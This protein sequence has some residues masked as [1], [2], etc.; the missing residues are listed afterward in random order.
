MPILSKHMFARIPIT[1]ARSSGGVRPRRWQAP[2]LLCVLA[3]AFVLP[4]SRAATPTTQ[5]AQVEAT[6][7]RYRSV[8]ASQPTAD[9]HAAL[10]WVLSR[11]KSDNEQAL[12]EADEAL[13]LDPSHF[14]A[15]EIAALVREMQGRDDQVLPHLL[16]MIGQDRPETSYYISRVGELTLS[17]S[18]RRTAIE[19]LRGFVSQPGRSVHRAVARWVLAELLLRDGQMDQARQTYQDIGWAQAWQVVGPFDNEANSGFG[20][21]YGPEKEIDFTRKYPGRGSPVSWRK[22]EH[23]SL[24]GLCNFASVMYPNDQVLAYAVTYA[25]APARTQAVIRLGADHSVKVWVNNRLV[26]SDD[27]NKGFA[28]DQHVAPVVLEPGFNTILVKVCRHGGEWR[29]GLRLTDPAGNPLENVAFSSEPPAGSAATSQHASTPSGSP[30]IPERTA[31]F[32]HD[33]GMLEYFSQEVARNRQNESAVYYLG[34]AQHA[35][36]RRTPATQTFEWLVSL[37][38][39]CSEYRV[40]LALAYSVDEQPDKAFEQLKSA[41]SLEPKNPRALMMLG[42]FY[43]SRE[44]MELARKTL[45]AAVAAAP[46]SMVTHYAL[47]QFYQARG[48]AFQ[49]FLKAKTLHETHPE[50]SLLTANYAALCNGYGYNEQSKSLWTQAVAQDRTNLTAWQALMDQAAR[51]SRIDDALKCGEVLQHLLPLSHS[52]RLGRVDL[53]LRRQAYEPAIALCKESL[54]ICPTQADVLNRLG[55]IYERMGKTS[56][57]I[58]SWR[59]ALLHKPDDRSLRDYLDFLQPQ[60]ENAAFAQYGVGAREAADLIA[61][62]RI[63][64]ASYPKASAVILLRHR[65]TQLFEDGSS[66]SQEHVV[67]KILNERGRQEYTKV[68]LGGSQPKVLR[69]VVIKPDGSEVE[70]TRVTAQEIHF[71]QLQ[72]GSVLEYKVIYHTQGTSWLSRHYNH[73][74]AFQSTVPLLRGQWVLVAP[75]DKTVK[76]VIRG[77]HVRFTRGEFQGQNVYDF[78]ADNVPMVEPEVAMPPTA[79]IVEQVRLSTIEDW[80]EIARWEYALIKDQ[81]E[82]DAAIRQKV[83]ELTATCAT[84]DERM[85]VLY[86]FVAQ[87]IQYKTAYTEGIFGVKPPKASN[88]LANEWGECKGKSA[89]LIAMLREAGITACYA[90]IRT[91]EAGQLVRELPSNQCNHAIVYVPDAQDFD[92]GLWLDATAEYYGLGTLPWGDRGVPAMVWRPDGRMQFKDVPQVK[93]HENLVRLIMEANL[94]GTGSAQARA[95]W[96]VT[97]DFA[98]GFRQQFRQVGQRK[99]QLEAVVT[100]LQPNGQLTDMAFSDLTDREAPVEIRFDFQAERYAEPASGSLILRPKRRFDLTARYA[101]RTDRQ[102][103][104]WLAMPSTVEYGEIYRYEPSWSVKTLPDSAKLDTPWISYEIRYAVETGVLR[105]EKKL[106][107]KAT[108]IPKNEYGRLRQFCIAADEHEQKTITLEKK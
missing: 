22:L 77:S 59:T 90:T 11:Y 42:R 52:I 4:C 29:M 27:Q 82:S 89:L 43:Q 104:L 66:S 63:D 86:N 57:A 8:L 70:A 2:T 84:S 94:S 61:S 65:V 85:R 99:Q 105:M 76:Y 39:N 101:P 37:N 13:R 81:F 16:A 72:S 102:Y 19:A 23:F 103:D 32:D 79:D 5:N 74:E 10:A 51:E 60:Q 64:E 44:S 36:N 15:H 49:A 80:D 24:S 97:G 107:V 14:K 71:S 41:L 46:Q 67:A 100:N 7:E 26:I 28:I 47:Q 95:H 38:K 69:A 88:V 54:A 75:R 50:V 20:V 12:R 9:N 3:A 31:E 34:L 33:R 93:P 98:A 6:V 56:E 40:L 21:S 55:G 106:I 92:R 108:D 17:V 68:P 45:D 58:S 91:R 53:L 18:Q 48:W 83:K 62:T 25:K 78:R 73:V 96:S 87:K 1:S 30:S 35:A